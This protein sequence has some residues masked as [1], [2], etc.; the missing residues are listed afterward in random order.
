MLV[1]DT[2][3]RSHLSRSQPEFTENSLIHYVYSVLSNLPIS[4]TRL[5]QFQ[6]ETK[7][8]PVLQ[9]LTFYTTHEWPEKQIYNRFTSV[10]YPSQ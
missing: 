3:S 9:T 5:K 2:L 1:S 4:Q 10:L 6:L 7:N 8:N